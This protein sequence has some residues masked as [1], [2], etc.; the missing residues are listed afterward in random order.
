MPKDHAKIDLSGRIYGRWTVLGDTGLRGAKR[1]VIWECKCVCG[2]LRGVISGSLISGVST[3]C[4]CLRKEVSKVFHLT[5]Q[6][7]KDGKVSPTYSSWR[8]ML[9]RCYNPS[10]PF[11]DCYGGRGIG[12]CERWRH[13]FKNFLDDMGIKPKG[14]SIDRINNDEGYSPENCRWATPSEQSNNQRKRKSA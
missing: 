6:H 13:N 2:S 12:V 4:G 1:E 8:N 10:R 14:T 7:A 9:Q 3:S 11:Y 5:H